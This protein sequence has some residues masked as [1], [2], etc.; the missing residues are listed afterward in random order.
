MDKMTLTVSS[1]PH[2]RSKRTTQNIMADVVIALI[3]ALL[4]GIIVFGLRAL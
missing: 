3:P 4:S 2:I 1:S